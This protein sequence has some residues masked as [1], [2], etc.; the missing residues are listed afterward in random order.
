MGLGGPGAKACRD[1]IADLGVDNNGSPGCSGF[2]HSC[3]NYT[4]MKSLYVFS[5]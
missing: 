4:V 3:E 5:I 2:I 1:P